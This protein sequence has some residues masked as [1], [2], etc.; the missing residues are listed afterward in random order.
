MT[1][2]EPTTPQKFREIE[3]SPL[4]QCVEDHHKAVHKGFGFCGMATCDIEKYENF[5]QRC[6]AARCRPPSLYAYLAR[7]LGVVLSPQPELLAVR[8]KGKLLIPSRVDALV[9]VEVSAYDGSQ[10]VASLH[11][12]DLGGR[13]LHDIAEEMKVRLR[14]AKR[15]TVQ[16]PV[17]RRRFVP[18]WAPSWWRRSVA[19]VRDLRPV[20]QREY[21]MRN[22]CVQISSTTQG[23]NGK[24]G[25]GVQLYAPMALSV[26]VSGSSRRPV[27]TDKGEVAV[28]SCL[29]V[30]LSFNHVIVDGA[31][32]TRFIAAFVKE[33]ES[34]RLLDEYPIQPRKPLRCQ[35]QQEKTTSGD[36]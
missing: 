9:A 26:M 16:L 5:V 19:T 29:D 27:A 35:L 6:R 25:W 24:G 20:A 17:E 31:P 22:A 18:L 13:P 10:A 11:F 4:R 21:A 32:A 23:V 33:V 30:A 12:A 8:V 15:T 1:A 2:T 3:F 34:G 36:I 14:S 28:H 7:C